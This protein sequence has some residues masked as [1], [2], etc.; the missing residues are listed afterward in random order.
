MWLHYNE[1]LYDNNNSIYPQELLNLDTEVQY[2]WNDKGLGNLP[3]TYQNKFTISIVA[4]LQWSPA[5]KFNWLF[6]IWAAREIQD[7]TYLSIQLHHTSIPTIKLKY[8]ACKTR[9]AAW[10]THQHQLLFPSYL[11]LHIY[12]ITVRHLPRLLALCLSL[13]AFASWHLVCCKP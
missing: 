11:Y 12:I 7:N 4:L 8:V 9:A 5:T 3:H 13:D 2:K 10:K 6:K 1:V